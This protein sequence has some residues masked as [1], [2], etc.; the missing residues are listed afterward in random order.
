MKA[1]WETLSVRERGLVAGGMTLVLILMIYALVWEPF[2]TSGRPAPSERGRTARR[3]GLDA[4]GGRGGQAPERRRQRL[5]IR[6]RWPLPADPGRSDRAGGGAGTGPEAARAT[7]EDKLSAQLDAV[8]F[9]QLIP[10]LGALERE[11]RIAIA[12]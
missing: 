8:E 7:G 12:T 10:W 11:H 3:P 4:A 9:D 6:R 1:W 2:R 5:R